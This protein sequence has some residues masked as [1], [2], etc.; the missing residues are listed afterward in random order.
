MK[1]RILVNVE[2]KDHPEACNLMVTNKAD[3]A[4]TLALMLEKGLV[5]FSFQQDGEII[6]AFGTKNEQIVSFFM[7]G[8]EFLTMADA[9]QERVDAD[10]NIIDLTEQV[11]MHLENMRKHARTKFVYV[12]ND[13]HQTMH[14]YDVNKG[15]EVVFNKNLILTIHV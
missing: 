2:G 5:L 8:P 15:H 12:G 1:N 13:S 4:E 9:I 10:L 14:Y 11:M 7:Y 3:M 6:E